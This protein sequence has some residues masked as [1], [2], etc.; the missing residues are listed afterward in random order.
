MCVRYTHAYIKRTTGGYRVYDALP[1]ALWKT[2]LIDLK[3][4]R[5]S[6]HRVQQQIS[7]PCIERRGTFFAINARLFCLKAKSSIQKLYWLSSKKFSA[8]LIQAKR[9]CVRAFMRFILRVLYYARSQKMSHCCSCSLARARPCCVVGWGNTYIPVR[10]STGT[11]P[12]VACIYIER[13]LS[14]RKKKKDVFW[15]LGTAHCMSRFHQ[16]S[17]KQQLLCSP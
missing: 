3:L 16:I 15:Q 9:L 8:L 7:I 4:D 17:S 2:K 6:S 14:P 13:L 11:I 1:T 5:V 12:W 10:T